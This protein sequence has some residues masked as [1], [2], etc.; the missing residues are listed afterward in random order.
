[1]LESPTGT[2]KTLALL[3]ST[4][5]WLD[6]KKFEDLDLKL[7][8]IEPKEKL[9]SAENLII[10][11]NDV[12]GGGGKN[13]KKTWKNDNAIRIIYSS[14]TH[15]QLSQA[16]NELKNSYYRFCP[17]VTIGSRDQLCINPDVANLEVK[18]AKNQTC[19]HKVKNNLCTYHHN[20]ERKISDIRMTNSKV[21]DIE[22]LMKFGNEHKACPYYLSKS[23][24][25]SSLV[26]MPY[27][28][29]LDPSIRKTFKLNLENS[30]IIFD[31]GH[32]I[33]QV[34]QDSMS[35][36][37]KSDFLALFIKSFDA[38]LLSLNQLNEGKYQGISD[39]EL[40]ELNIHDVA[41]VKLTI[42]DLEVELDSLA[43]LSKNGAHDTGEIFKIMQ[44]INLD[45]ER[46]QLICSVVEKMTP[47]IMNSNSFMTNQTLAALSSVCSFL[48]IIFPFS[49]IKNDEFVKYKKEFIKNYKL[50]TE[51]EQDNSYKKTWLK[52]DTVTGWIVHLW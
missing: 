48:E 35:T 2:G 6:H 8:G 7:K 26:F 27:N 30:V 31:E 50:Y 5:A 47:Y 25:D 51:M 17:T 46:Y 21:F 34:C 33:E 12:G 23:M 32:N 41:K 10:S 52:T 43:K 9:P 36:E 29:V 38:V 16:C 49:N 40:S 24:K 15:S 37:I 42:C 44:K 11:D 14:R 39:K 18:S 22:D 3:C 45:F 28:Y 20:Y 4:L 1:M 13:D 19:H